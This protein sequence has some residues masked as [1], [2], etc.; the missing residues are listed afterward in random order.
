[1]GVPPSSDVPNLATEPLSDL[2]WIFD[3]EMV[4]Q[5]PHHR[6]DGLLTENN[7]LD[8]NPL[9]PLDT[10]LE[11]GSFASLRNQPSD[12]SDIDPNIRIEL[13]HMNPQL[14]D[15]L[16]LD[17]YPYSST[18]QSMP[19]QPL[20]NEPVQ[21][22]LKPTEIHPSLSNVGQQTLA[23]HVAYSST[24]GSSLAATSPEDS[25]NNLYTSH[26]YQ[27]DQ[28]SSDDS[29]LPRSSV[30]RTSTL[31]SSIGVDTQRIPNTKCERL[32]DKRG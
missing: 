4:D 20:P 2:D 6:I 24:G 11:S 26:D 18:G 19:N 12:R 27:T 7:S 14:P 25:V 17:S 28:E 13:E 1:M 15:H 9:T 16:D 5:L 10:S 32:E 23:E 31:S 21:K 3:L 29:H 30:A 22:R 8:H